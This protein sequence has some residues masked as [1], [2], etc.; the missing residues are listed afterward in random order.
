MEDDNVIYTDYNVIKPLVWEAYYGWVKKYSQYIMPHNDKRLFDENGMMQY[1]VQFITFTF[2]NY[3]KFNKLDKQKTEII[4]ELFRRLK[5]Q[6]RLKSYEY[7]YINDFF[8]EYIDVSGIGDY[9][10]QKEDKGKAVLRTR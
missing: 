10:S 3:H 1:A 2:R 8:A 7:E 4:I 6:Q 9:V 5:S